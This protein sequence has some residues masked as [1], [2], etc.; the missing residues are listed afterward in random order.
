MAQVAHSFVW[1]VQDDV[2][3]TAISN[4]HDNNNR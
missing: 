4:D 3:L 2:W 1:F